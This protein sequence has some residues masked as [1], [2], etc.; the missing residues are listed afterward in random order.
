L[1]RF[2]SGLGSDETV[3]ECSDQDS[4]KE[5]QPAIEDRQRGGEMIRAK[6]L[7]RR[8]IIQS[9]AILECV[10]QVLRPY[11]QPIP[12]QPAYSFRAIIQRQSQVDR[13]PRPPTTK[14]PYAAARRLA[15]VISTLPTLNQRNIER[16]T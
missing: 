7:W 1:Q 8:L 2:G 13:A 4:K 14:V 5:R 16:H 3:T 9:R 15:K 12:A 11:A 6:S 10:S